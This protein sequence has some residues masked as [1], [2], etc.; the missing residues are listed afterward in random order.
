[1]PTHTE[2]QYN[3]TGSDM[4]FGKLA[5]PQYPNAHTHLLLTAM[6]PPAV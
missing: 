5:G 3:T 2:A 1:M 6:H 4:P